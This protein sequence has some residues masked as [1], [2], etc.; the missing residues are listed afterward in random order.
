MFSKAEQ[1]EIFALLRFARAYSAEKLPWF[2]PALFKCRIHLTEQVPVAAIDGHFNVYFN[3]GAV[4][5]IGQGYSKIEALMQIGFIWIHEISHVL[6]EHGQRAKDRHAEHILWNIACDF[7]INDSQWTGLKIPEAFPP[8]LPHKFGLPQGQI[9]EFYY[10]DILKNGTE[11]FEVEIVPLPGFSAGEMLDEGSGVHGQPRPWEL[12]GGEA[13]RMDEIEVE[14]VRRSVAHEIQKAKKM[15]GTGIGT[16][17]GNWLRWADL[18]LKPK[19]NWRKVLR[20]RMSVAINSGVGSRIDYSFRRPSRRQAIYHPVITPVLGG[21]LSARVAV[22]IDTSGSMHNRQIG[23][24]VAE[25][26]EILN[27]FQVPVTVI[28]CDAVA[29]ESFRITSPSDFFKMKQLKGGGGTDMVA[30]IEAALLNRPKPDSIL[31][32]TD[33]YTPFP[34]KKYAVNV[35][36]G[37]IKMNEDYETPKPPNPPWGDDSVVVISVGEGEY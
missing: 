17:A 6:R 20:N 29:Y 14:L 33:G 5:V 2:A 19:V 24:A 15:G 7:E 4:Q 8:L 11:Q 22:V 34:E 3:P 18:T 37:I 27:T 16:M 10:R 1:N 31:V 28:P 13:Q 25:V 30:G 23:Q 21:D 26:F 12:G 35:V 36:F 9:A 32:L